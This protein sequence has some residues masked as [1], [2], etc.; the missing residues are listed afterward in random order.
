MSKIL[1]WFFRAIPLYRIFANYALFI[2]HPNIYYRAS[3]NNG[4]LVEAFND[5]E[6]LLKYIKKIGGRYIFLTNNSSKSVDRYVGKLAALGIEAGYDDFLT[7]TDDTI[8]FL[9]KKYK[10][11]KVYV[12]GTKSFREQLAGA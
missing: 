9:N 3:L 5:G 7:S 6:E 4:S 1:S 11:K 12:F 10:E 8:H 2:L